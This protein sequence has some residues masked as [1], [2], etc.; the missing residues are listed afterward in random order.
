MMRLVI[1][2]LALGLLALPAHAQ[3]GSVNI[4]GNIFDAPP[5]QGYAAPPAQGERLRLDNDEALF[6][7]QPCNEGALW[8]GL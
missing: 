2:S 5:E 1:L 6:L 8:H 3:R 7:R 4:N